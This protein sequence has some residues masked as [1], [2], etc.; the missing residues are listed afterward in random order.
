MN[1]M[2][3]FFNVLIDLS[4]TNRRVILFFFLLLF[5]IQG[6]YDAI[7]QW[8]TRGYVGGTFF[9][10][11]PNVIYRSQYS[12]LSKSSDSGKTWQ[13]VKKDQFTNYDI[14]K[15]LIFETGDVKLHFINESI[16]FYFGAN[17]IGTHEVIFR[18]IDS[19]ATW[20]LV[21]DRFNGRINEITFISETEGFAIG[22]SGLLLKT[23]NGG[24]NWSLIPTSVSNS[25][26]DLVA[27]DVNHIYIATD[28][29]I[30]ITNNGGDTWSQFELPEAA[31]SVS[32]LNDQVGIVT[33]LNHLFVTQ[34]AGVTW[35]I[36]SGGIPANVKFTETRNAT[37]Q[38]LWLMTDKG[39]Y[40]STNGLFWSPQ[41]AIGELTIYEVGTFEQSIF[42]STNLNNFYSSIGGDPVPGNELEVYSIYTVP[43]DE[44]RGVYPVKARIINRGFNFLE[45][46][47][48]GY[49]I[50]GIQQPIYNWIGRL[51]PGDT[52]N[53]ILVGYFDYLKTAHKHDLKIWSFEPNGTE[54]EYLNND[55]SSVAQSFNKFVGVYTIG[56]EEESDFQS[57]SRA[58]NLLS[59]YGFCS[60]D[61]VSFVVNPGLYYE[62]FDLSLNS[63]YSGQQIIIKSLTGNPADVV[64]ESNGLGF[65]VSNGN[66]SISGITWKA[67]T[68]NVFTLGVSSNA[69]S[70][71]NLKLFNN[72]IVGGNNY[73]NNAIEIRSILGQVTIEKNTIRK[74]Y[75]GIQHAGFKGKS[76][77]AVI[78]VYANTFYDQEYSG[79]NF[80]HSDAKIS[81]LLNKVSY[82]EIPNLG[83]CLNLN[84]LSKPVRVINNSFNV[85]SA[86]GIRI[87]KTIDT[88][89]FYNT[90]YGGSWQTLYVSSTKSTSV[91]NNIL[92]NE[93]GVLLNFD[94]NIDLISDY[95]C[96]FTKNVLASPDPL[97]DDF[98][99]KE[100]EVWQS[101]SGQDF[102]SI[103]ADPQLPLNDYH[104]SVVTQNYKLNGAAKPLDVVKTDIDGDLRDSISPDIG[105]DEFLIPTRDLAIVELTNRGSICIGDK[106]LTLNIQNF[107]NDL[108]SGYQVNWQIGELEK[109][110]ITNPPAVDLGKQIQLQLPIGYLEDGEYKTHVWLSGVTNDGAIRNDSITTFISIRA[111]L[112]GTYTVGGVGGD[113]DNLGDV[114][115]ALEST[116]ICGPVVIK[117]RPGTYNEEVKI[118]SYHGLSKINTL[119][120]ESESLDSSSVVIM[121]NQ[122]P[123]EFVN[124]SWIQ[125]RSITVNSLGQAI[126]LDEVE[127]ITISNCVVTGGIIGG[128]K[129]FNR[130]TVQNT[131]FKNPFAPW[132][133]FLAIQFGA[134]AYLGYKNAVLNNVFEKDCELVLFRQHGFE[135]VGNISTNF[136]LSVDG[137]QGDYR[138]E[139]NKLSG[140]LI[141][142]GYNKGLSI[143]TIANNFINGVYP[144]EFI[145]VD[146]VKILHNTIICN[147]AEGINAAL[148]IN[149]FQS[150]PNLFD[151][152]EVKNNI[153]V[154]LKG[155]M[156]VVYNTS[157]GIDVSHNT[158]WSIHKTP[159][160]TTTGR[161]FRE[162]PD[163]FYFDALDKY[164]NRSG[165]DYGSQ[166][167]LPYFKDVGDYH[168]LGDSRLK[169]MGTFVSV[170]SDLDGEFRNTNNPDPGAD[171][172]DVMASTYDAGV[173]TVRRPNE[174][175]NKQKV[176][177]RIKNYGTATLTSADIKWKSSNGLVTTSKWTGSLEQN[178]VSND[179]E[180]G[181]IDLVPTDTFSI[182]AW[183]ELPNGFTD[184]VLLNDSS[185]LQNIFQK[186]IGDYTIGG[187][188]AHFDSPRQAI[189]YLNNVGICGDVNLSIQPGTYEGG[190]YIHAIDGAT[191]ENQIHLR[192]ASLDS[193]SVIINASDWTFDPKESRIPYTILFNGAKFISL[194]GIQ[195]K[196]DY[197]VAAVVLNNSS[198]NITISNCWI[199]GNGSESHEDRGLVVFDITDGSIDSTLIENNFLENGKNGVSMYND[200]GSNRLSNLKIRKNRFFNQALNSVALSRGINVHVEGN[201]I[202]RILNNSSDS[203]GILIYDSCKNTYVVGNY[204]R[205]KFVTGIGLRYSKEVLIANNLVNKLMYGISSMYGSDNRLV[206]NTVKSLDGT[207]IYIYSDSG[208]LMMNNN[209]T[210]DGSGYF[211][212]LK[213]FPYGSIN[214]VD[215][216]NYFGSGLFGRGSKS[217]TD[218][219]NFAQSTGLEIHS[220]SVDPEY[221]SDSDFRPQNPELKG[222]AVSVAMVNDDYEGISRGVDPTIGA[223]E[224]SWFA[225]NCQLE[226]VRVESCKEIKVVFSNSGTTIV[227]NLTIGWSVGGVPQPPISWVGRLLPNQSTLPIYVGLVNNAGVDSEVR[228]WLDNPNGLADS[229]LGN[230]SGTYNY[231][232]YP[233]IDLG[234]DIVA[235]L[236]TTEPLEVI[237]PNYY[238]SYQWSN[239]W[240]ENKMYALSSGIYS[241]QVID[242]NGCVS[243]DDVGI[244][245]T[246]LIKPEIILDGNRLICTITGDSY[247]WLLNEEPINEGNGQEYLLLKEGDYQVV[248]FLN[249]CSSTSEAVHITVTGVDE[250]ENVVIYPNPVEDGVIHIKDLSKN[251]AR[252]Y[253]KNS[254]GHNIDISWVRK[255]DSGLD[256]GLEGISPGVY[257]LELLIDGKLQFFKIVI[258]E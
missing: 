199:R 164:Q 154:A 178:K 23:T 11:S 235:C 134:Y 12:Y 122:I 4:S 77:L 157:N 257:F 150:T 149:S 20:T 139:N 72:E 120:F 195:V 58:I 216:N 34:D 187:N 68:G 127:D 18:T 153:I 214:T 138:I 42:L 188:N 250:I 75:T 78:D 57:L 85:R 231:K 233:P 44:C 21:H 183:T 167:L 37:N 205:G 51:A 97:Y 171:E 221:I 211:V 166:F 5:F 158:Y 249:G 133:N 245:M 193:T 173:V 93:G 179:I 190:F 160:L 256:I 146:N 163:N 228:L 118:K 129:L 141:N 161:V 54:D 246:T 9:M 19:G 74:G 116:G 186:L 220:I 165:L 126:K 100:I 40:K 209:V 117:I 238:K 237:A 60:E 254:I 46:A 3:L 67:Q 29:G 191:Y 123:I 22:E 64:I 202:N 49:S 255:V 110:V 222:K 47:R 200:Y 247:Q 185:I 172:F 108:I 92:A 130:V 104:L 15:S 180:L 66:I 252:V 39:L 69:T 248:V 151:N 119:T 30:R 143:G 107:G 253:L 83:Y 62:D 53:Y 25:F 177:A 80:E 35:I 88:D 192:S 197:N 242:D 218:V 89:F 215:Y 182:Q 219:E 95:N 223:F 225:A 148:D 36:T 234:N 212:Y 26:V 198:S 131:L 176:F 224:F 70:V 124:T 52:S 128:G 7:A 10:V 14:S 65:N 114:L 230:N 55:T 213:D 41:R 84:D 103:Q 136:F 16:G 227:R 174:C 56:G 236:D 135:V 132:E 217:F 91:L 232:T 142:G 76:D 175:G 210:H 147:N 105:A 204:V 79:I 201:D 101:Y 1:C 184:E 162:Y 8:Q 226:S 27:T 258:N 113:F 38:F 125:F 109:S 170:S 229:F 28:N 90:V 17:L 98:G 43:E 189:T 155:A 111:G 206:Y 99:I 181:V 31:T 140:L 194:S 203:H 240:F 145:N 33:T 61:T 94:K 48:L 239:G 50:D 241:L 159:F 2:L 71:L 87:E 168:I 86:I 121:S 169:G 32:F 73:N 156:A 207:A 208:I 112:S 196:A 59:I 243:T 137:A 45:S 115:S 244:T 82:G 6:S 96:L 144:N 102:H 152:I 106:S 63:L 13:N 81:I 24:V 251:D